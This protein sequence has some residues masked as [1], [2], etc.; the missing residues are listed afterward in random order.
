MPTYFSSH[1]QDLET[2]PLINTRFQVGDG[3]TGWKPILGQK[4]TE[5]IHREAR[6][7]WT[8]HCLDPELEL[9]SLK[10]IFAYSLTQNNPEV[11]R[12]LIWMQ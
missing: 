11:E 3:G 2:L 5:V 10:A 9:S 12:V 6:A 1:G 4:E 7:L 8:F